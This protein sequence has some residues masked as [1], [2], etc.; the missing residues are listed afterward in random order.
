MK[1]ESTLPV[2]YRLVA[3]SMLVLLTGCVLLTAQNVVLTGALSGRVTDPSGAVVPGASVVI[4]NLQTSIKQSVETNRAGLYRFP[5]LTP[6][7]YS[8]AATL[9]G[10]RD[11]Q[12]LIQVLVGNTT[13]LDIRLQVGASGEAVK[14]SGTAPLLRPA[15]S[16][17]S[18]V[19]DRSFIEDLPLNGRKYTDFTVKAL[20]PFPLAYP[21]SSPPCCPAML[22]RPVSPS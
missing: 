16:S 2:L 14:V 17:A 9:K 5:V 21:E 13:S 4:S 1:K 8:I 20:P 19:L 22:T 18:T 10:F 15:E 7:S 6:G 11:A 3:C 12:G